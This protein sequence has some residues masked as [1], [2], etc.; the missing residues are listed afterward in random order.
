LFSQGPDHGGLDVT[1]LA[2]TATA[3]LASADE[4]TAGKAAIPPMMTVA[5][6]RAMRCLSFQLAA[7]LLMLGPFVS[8]GGRGV[9]P[10]SCKLCQ[11]AFA[12][13]SVRE[14]QPIAG[15]VKL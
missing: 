12:A 11:A 4:T 1:E 8:C 10:L 7:C 15:R 14:G 13:L 2:V 6:I 3:G 5:L 9:R